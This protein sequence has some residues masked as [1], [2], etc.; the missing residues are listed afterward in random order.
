MNNLKNIWDKIERKAIYTV[1]FLFVIAELV[2]LVFPSISAFMDTKGTLSLLALVLLFIFRFLDEKLAD[3]KSDEPVVTN[4]ILKGLGELLGDNENYKTI[5][6]FAHTSNVYYLAFNDSLARVGQL[7]LLLRDMDD[8]ETIQFPAG[9][10][11]K[12]TIKD[13]ME[14]TLKEWKDMVDIGRIGD[15]KICYYPF[16]PTVNFI[17]VDGKKMLTGL[18]RLEKQ[19]PGVKSADQDTF[20]F[21]ESSEFGRHMI[22]SYQEFYNNITKE[23]S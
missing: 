16:E 21:N 6:I 19:F 15:I 18:N 17:I 2:S 14:I 22:Q 5:D 3:F 12:I 7:R 4:G 23:F 13:R 10:R 8:L 1:L 9:Q 20:I 11:D